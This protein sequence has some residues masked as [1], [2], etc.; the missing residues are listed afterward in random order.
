MDLR[1]ILKGTRLKSNV[2]RLGITKIC[3]NS[4]E[5]GAGSLFIALQ[6]HAHDGHDFALDAYKRG[7]RA[8]V[9]Q[10]ALGL[11]DDAHVIIVPDSRR[12]L[13][14]AAAKF[15]A[16]PSLELKVYAVVGTNGK[17]TTSYILESILEAAGLTPGVIGTI[18]Y[19]YAD[20]EIA[21]VNTTPEALDLQMLMRR[22]K[23][24][25]VKSVVMEVS[26]HAL[27]QGRVDGVLF[28][29]GIFTNL[30]QD[31]LDYHM[32]MRNYYLSKRRIFSKALKASAR[33]KSVWAA[34]NID[35]KYGKELFNEFSTDF[36]IIPFGMGQCDGVY[37]K[38]AKN[39]VDGL[40][41]AI[42]TPGGA[43]SIDSRLTG[44]FNIYNIL[45]AVALSVGEGIPLDTIKRGVEKLRDIPG[46]MQKISSDS[47]TI[48]VDY[49]HTPDALLRVIE[50]VREIT[51][52]SRVITIFG[53][54]GDRDKGKRAKMG[55]IAARLS[56][57][58]IITS[59]NPRS[60]E[61][62]DIINEILV[63]FK[64]SGMDRLDG[65][66]GAEK[67]YLAHVDRKT[68]IATAVSMMR[69]GDVV[70]VAG[71]GHEDYQIIKGEVI[72]FNDVEVIRECLAQNDIKVSD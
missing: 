4:R 6:G 48:F 59:D 32:N 49:A 17:T 51:G 21:A 50:S 20:K 70:I 12:V 56:D 68:A 33:K 25:D 28:D 41:L 29:A 43:L 71:K 11:P 55:E 66:T 19:R 24:E 3:Y 35:D 61:P 38:S 16:N 15:Y 44:E 26:S 30:T 45:G 60:E 40:K 37:I 8:F 39:S 58:S 53:C 54:G 2:T 9:S 64:K 34:V 14:I 72:H 7:A 23:D 31:H 10:R 1:D 22:M 67:G 63:P 46:R 18:N 62:I 52:V 65:S 5:C 36:N 57:I 47:G 27:H 42:D 69:S 13:R